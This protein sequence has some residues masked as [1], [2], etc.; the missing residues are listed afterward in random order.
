MDNARLGHSIDPWCSVRGLRY[1]LLIVLHR[2]VRA[3]R[4]KSMTWIHV[5][6]SVA[7][8]EKWKPVFDETAAYKRAHGW[9]RYQVFA[10]GGN[11]N[12]MMVM[13]EFDTREHAQEFLDS[14]YLR[15]AMARAGVS[16]G[17]E[18]LVVEELEEGT[19]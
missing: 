18:F 3:E 6:F 16:R 7:D 8:Y 2:S 15:E 13:E 17:P 14:A 12:D 9:Q 5:R 11:R 10:V 19:S 4:G 1:T